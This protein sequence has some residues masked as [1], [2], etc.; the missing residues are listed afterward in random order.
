MMILFIKGKNSKPLWPSV[1][2]ILPPGCSNQLLTFGRVF[3]MTVEKFCSTLLCRDVFISATL[4]AFLRV[5]CLFKVTAQHLSW[6]Q[7]QY[8]TWPL[9]NLIYYLL[10]VFWKPFGGGLASVFLV[11]LLNN[12]S[13]FE[14]EILNCWPDVLLWDFLNAQLHQS[15]QSSPRPSRHHHIWLLLWSSF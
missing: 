4:E 7:V 9:Q 12:T 6:M 11:I 14:L 13:A 15:Q 5:N 2:S 1:K 3:L 8:L 10:I